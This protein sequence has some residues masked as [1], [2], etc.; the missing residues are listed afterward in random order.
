VDGA[1]PDRSGRGRLVLKARL[2]MGTGR[3]L[4]LAI[5]P[6]L[7]LEACYGTE[8]DRVAPS[9][10]VVRSLYAGNPRV[11]WEVEVPASGSLALIAREGWVPRPLP[12]REG[13]RARVV[14][15]TKGLYHVMLTAARLGEGRYEPVEMRDLVLLVHDRQVLPFRLTMSGGAATHR[16]SLERFQGLDVVGEVTA[17]LRFF[18]G[19]FHPLPEL[20][21]AECTGLPAL[22]MSFPRL[23]AFDRELLSAPATL[24]FRFLP[25]EIAHQW[26][27]LRVRFAGE[28]R[29]WLQESLAEYLQLLYLRRRLGERIF[30]RG[31]R[32]SL[33]CYRRTFPDGEAPTPGARGAPGDAERYEGLA[34]KGTLIWHRFHELIGDRGFYRLMKLLVAQP[35]P[36]TLTDFE[37]LAENAC[38][39]AV[40]ELRDELRAITSRERT[41][42]RTQERRWN[43]ST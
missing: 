25:H 34:A 42:G 28:G 8:I 15:R 18:S 16:E 7:E 40:D 22:A 14:V 27:G 43:T 41:E 29:L 3:R 4:A 19:L 39:I 12:S 9:L 30:E 13:D 36:V 32:W 17:M 26:M 37:R 23:V 5:H 38:S 6:S 24:L 20:T 10:A 31:L 33:Q 21:I 1:P 35:S 11:R 2:P